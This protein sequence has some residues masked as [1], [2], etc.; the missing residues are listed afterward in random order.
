MRKL[1]L[2]ALIF[3]GPLAWN[4]AALDVGGYSVDNG[5]VSAGPSA[6]KPPTPDSEYTAIYYSKCGN[7]HDYNVYT[8]KDGTYKEYSPGDPGYNELIKFKDSPQFQK[9]Q[10]D[11][12]TYNAEVAKATPTERKNLPGPPSVK[13]PTVPDKPIKSDAP[14]GPVHDDPK[15]DLAFWFRG[16]QYHDTCA[17][18]S[19][20]HPPEPA[21]GLS[22]PSA[23]PGVGN[24]QYGMLVKLLAL[25]PNATVPGPNKLLENFETFFQNGWRLTLGFEK[26]PSSKVLGADL[27]KASGEVQKSL[28]RLE[29][30]KRQSSANADAKL[31]LAA[32]SA[33]AEKE[34]KA[35]KERF[36]GLREQL[37]KRLEFIRA[38]VNLLR[39]APEGGFGPTFA[40]IETGK[41][42]TQ[43]AR[44]LADLG[45]LAGQALLSGLAQDVAWLAANPNADKA[46]DSEFDR[47]TKAVEKAEELLWDSRVD[48]LFAVSEFL[49]E[50][51]SA[52]PAV[53]KQALELL[54][55]LGTKALRPEV[56]ATFPRLIA[57]QADSKQPAEI[58]ARAKSVFLDLLKIR[59]GQASMEET[60]GVLAPLLKSSDRVIA[61]SVEAFLTAHTGQKLG[62]D[63]QAWLK[64]KEKMA[65]AREKPAAK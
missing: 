8:F 35:L 3:T 26:D 55:K 62:R 57:L 42:Q 51:T 37:D 33:Q 2:A 61:D 4:A 64:L 30:L 48:G 43:A 21:A 23:G 39:L 5:K 9:Y 60:V 7:A 16:F 22:D 28:A 19:P 27:E 58:S 25:D 46:P 1:T 40:E 31:D 13:G 32:S 47:R 38:T 12:A 20:E 53:L 63:P 24:N 10:Q 11:L 18:I 45:P 65:A 29:E 49:R 54:D 44:V 56:L 34:A 52:N 17:Q 59:D 15:R 14:S 50:G 41:L 36:D 6:P